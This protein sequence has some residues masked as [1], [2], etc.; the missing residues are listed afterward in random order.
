MGKW[1][2]RGFIAAGLA[3]GGVFTVG[4]AVREGHRA[5]KL[6]AMMEG[7]DETLVNVWVKLSKDNVVTAIIPHSEMGQGVWT[8]LAQ[9]L[10]DEMD[11]DWDLVKFEQAPAHEAYANFALGRDFVMGETTVPGFVQDTLNGSFLRISQSMSLQITGGSTSV[12]F[13]GQGGMRIAGAAAKDMIIRATAKSWGVSRS[14]IRTEKS[15]VYHDA[16]GRVAPYAEFAEAAAELRPPTQPT[17]KTSGEFNIMGQSKPR[18]DIPEKVDGTAEFALDVDLPGMSYAAVMGP[19]VFGATVQS[20]DETYTRGMSGIHKILNEGDFVAV[21]ADSYWTAENAVRALDVSWTQTGREGLNQEAIYDGF[22]ADMASAVENGDEN[23]HVKIGNARQAV[24]SAAQQVEAEYTVPYLAH[25]CMEPMNAVAQVSSGSVDIWVGHQNPLG[26]RDA[27]SKTLGYDKEAVT[28]HNRLM[29]GGFGR[30]SEAD[31]PLMAVRIAQSV[32]GPVKMIWSR[33]E[34]TRQ[35]FYRPATTAKVIAGLGEDGQPV[36]WDYQFVHQHDPVEASEIVYNI[37]NQFVHWAETENP[38][39]FGPWRSVDHTQHGFFIESFIDE[40]AHTAGQDPLAYRRNLV[41]N[42]PRHV[43]LLDAVEEA[44]GWGRQMPAGRG[45]GVGLVESF[46]TIVAE[47]VEVDVTGPV[48]KV[49]NVWAACD[50]GFVMNPDGFK[51]QIESGIIYGL[52][53]TL[54]GDIT[55]ENGA[56]VQ[57]NFHDYPILRIDEAPNIDVMIINSNARVGGGGEPGT[58]P[59]APAVTNAIFAATGQRVRALPVST[60]TLGGV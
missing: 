7:E 36:S 18:Y 57:S 2:R 51:A 5:P 17:L 1:T 24:E 35:G 40:L 15:F 11:A 21:V 34:A 8:P 13:T 33:E 22:R 9:M 26:V 31:Y 43:A 49:I 41:A 48:P 27:I 52:T 20:V 55:V 29:G 28:V 53:A 23:K 56:I 38:I 19:P 37:P 10:A 16:S 58:P 50:A 42:K 60:E 6:A 12:R 3:A 47:V 30:K 32:D 14:E 44:S 59:I 54:Y 25:A 39:R 4:V 46:G 45:L